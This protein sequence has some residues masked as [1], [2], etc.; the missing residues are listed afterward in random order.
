MNIIEYDRYKVLAYAE[1]WALGRNPEY[2]SF[3]EIG[4]DCTNFVSQCVYAGCGIMNYTPVTGWY[5]INANDR[6]ASW[7]G[8]NYFFR[9]ITNNLGSGP[10]GIE[11]PRSGLLTGDVI[12]LGRSKEEYYH[13][14]IVMSTSAND[15]LLAAHSNDALFRPL[16]SYH[17]NYIRCI[18]II[19]ARDE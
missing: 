4:G 13:S 3:N 18:H 16:S 15:I 10:F 7:T 1:K 6:T 17:Y 8:V 19:A 11:V 5:Y 12:Q 9:F 2:Y 14:L